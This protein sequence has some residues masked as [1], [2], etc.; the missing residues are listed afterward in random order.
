ML[1]VAA[2]SFSTKLFNYPSVT[3]T[4][5]PVNG[6]IETSIVN[7][8]LSYATP[9]GDYHFDWEPSVNAWQLK[10]EIGGEEPETVILAQSNPL[11]T[12]FPWASTWPAGVT[13]QA[14][15]SVGTNYFVAGTDPFVPTFQAAN[16]CIA[17]GF[18]AGYATAGANDCISIGTYANQEGRSGGN[19]TSGNNC[20]AIGN[21][22]L[23]QN[24]GANN[25][26][27]G[28][29]ALRFPNKSDCIAIGVGSFADIAVRTNSVALGAYAAPTASNQIRLGNA[30]ITAVVSQV[31]SWSDERDKADIRDTILG[32]DFIKKLRAVDY[33]WDYREDYRP[34][35][36]ALVPKP[37]ELDENASDE[38]KA[39]YKKQLEKYESYLVLVEKWGEDSKLANITSDGTHKRTRYH[40]GLIAQEVKSLIEQTGVDFGG[41]QDHTIKGGDD[42]MTI[43]YMELIG[44]MIKAIQEL[45]A[46]VTSLKAQLNP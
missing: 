42:A 32:L 45:S 8:K 41:F 2:E 37:E 43:S 19:T 27:I 18:N 36:P 23:W 31:G 16:R 30:N 26:G 35:C 11:G 39:E 40:H 44:P 10:Y 14:E 12:S 38:E 13:V 4:S 1:A 3:G 5:A 21:S 9:G 25:I 6:Y 34:E 46:E 17:I 33:K 24:N 7:S 28:E 22:A 29:G 15:G 20:I